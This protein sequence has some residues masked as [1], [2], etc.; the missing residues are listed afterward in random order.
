MHITL[1]D[2]TSFELP[3]EGDVYKLN[4]SLCADFPGLGMRPED[5][6]CIQC[7]EEANLAHRRSPRGCNRRCF[8]CGT[9]QHLGK[10]SLLAAL[11]STKLIFGRLARN[12]FRL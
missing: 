2:G 3:H 1:P 8:L 5:T 7:G 9:D 10:V 11:T 4:P 6:H 12:W